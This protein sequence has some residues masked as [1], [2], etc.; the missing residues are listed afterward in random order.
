M[1]KVCV[2]FGA[3]SYYD[4]IPVIPQG[5][6]VVAADGGYDHALSLGVTPDVA[7]GDFDS[8]SGMPDSRPD[9][10][11]SGGG[12]VRTIALPAQKDETDMPQAVKVGWNQGIRVFHI[13]GGLGGRLDH[14]LANLQ[15]LADIAR[16][17]GIGFLHGDGSVATAV[18]DGEIRFPANQVAARRMVSVFA[19]S[20]KAL[21]VT[22]R[23][24]KYETDPVDW[25]NSHALGVSNEFLPGI[26]SSISV[27]EGTLIVTYPVEAPQPQWRS[28]VEQDA[29][30]G[31]IDDR[32]SELLSPLFHG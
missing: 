20:D 3:G 31:E 18:T 1:G 24:L 4:E 13:F 12:R 15:M 23:G 14:A 11:M 9:G 2:V 25:T 27:R 5:A 32:R 16:H 21:G 26:P 6:L 22:I 8:I 17:G 10:G 19:H 29:S 28:G 30:F 7:I